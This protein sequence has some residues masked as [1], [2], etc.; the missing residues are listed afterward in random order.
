MD[1]DS[2]ELNHFKPAFLNV[3]GKA[4]HL[5]GSEAPANAIL[6]LKVFMCS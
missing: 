4:L 5:T 1:L 6:D 3:M 2:K